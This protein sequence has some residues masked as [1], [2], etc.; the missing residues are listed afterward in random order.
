MAKRLYVYASK[1]DAG[2]TLA[3]VAEQAAARAEADETLG[4]ANWTE[5]D[6]T[7]HVLPAFAE[8]VN[9]ARQ[10]ERTLDGTGRWRWRTIANVLKAWLEEPTDETCEACGQQLPAVIATSEPS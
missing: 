2:V 8:I 4:L 3:R 6:V 1:S 10:R 9:L 5:Y 7:A